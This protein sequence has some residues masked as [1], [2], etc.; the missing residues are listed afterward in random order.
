[1]ANVTELLDLAAQIRDADTAQE[2]TATRVGSLLIDMINI[3]GGFATTEELAAAVNNFS[4]SLSTYLE[5]Y[6]TLNAGKTTLDWKQSPVVFLESMGSSLDDVDGGTFNYSPATGDL[7]YENLS[8]YQIW[9][10][11]SS[12]KTGSQAKQGVAYINK[13][14][15]RV[16][17][18][19][20]S[21][22]VEIGSNGLNKYRVI[23]YMTIADLNEMSIGDVGFN[24]SSKKIT[25]KTGS[26]KWFSFSPDPRA[27][28]CDKTA[29]TAIIWDSDEEDW[30][31]IGS[32]GDY[33]DLDVEAITALVNFFGSGGTINTT[34]DADD[35][36]ESGYVIYD[37]NNGGEIS[38]SYSNFYHSDYL[39][40]PN[41]ATGFSWTQ[42]YGTS[43]KASGIAW[44]DSGKNFISG[45]QAASG[46]NTQ[47]GTTVT[48][49]IPTGAKFVRFTKFTGGNYSAVS[50][51]VLTGTSSGVEGWVE[52][53]KA[54]ILEELGGSSGGSSTPT[55]PFKILCVGNSFTKCT[56][57]Y[58]ADICNNLGVNNV[59]IQRLYK[60]GASLQDYD[61]MV[62]TNAFSSYSCSLINVVGTS[63]RSSATTLGGVFANTWDL[64]VFQQK[65][66]LADEY[67]SYEPYL[68]SLIN[69]V[70]MAC[71]NANVKFAWLM[72]WET[73]G[74]STA[75]ANYNDQANRFGAAASANNI[76]AAVKS[77][78]EDFGD[79]LAIIPIGTAIENI[80]NSSVNGSGAASFT[81]DN[82]HLNMGVGD[83]V[84]GCTFFASVLQAVTGK[85]IYDDTLTTNGDHDAQSSTG[86][87]DV[88]SSNRLTCQ[89][90]AVLAVI[91]PFEPTDI[92]NI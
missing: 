59:T 87:V 38:T 19:S 89:K 48:G 83:Y 22:M 34:Y 67:N 91:H 28:Y 16:Y 66:S 8:G 65:S 37:G 29:G 52:S 57:Q 71:G 10:K 80:R 31:V 25:V 76:V 13:H 72:T 12:G 43:G 69:K 20:G 40:V 86:A 63:G 41:G 27:V 61:D 14:T 81:R 58:M 62:L 26:S 73:Q 75:I 6:A 33:G 64:V 50:T 60:D 84:A 32:N 46:A 5:G 82:S 44:Y 92:D 88:T 23:D 21:A 2:N 49:T 45:V 36:T 1:M 70:K 17:E 4:S 54:E 42:N 47:D 51:L 18:W 30:V 3:I 56:M 77:M 68:T 24:T 79:N 78:K 39:A 85:N 74:S 55:G 7:F 35:C 9:L 11:N 53:L 90:A 15:L